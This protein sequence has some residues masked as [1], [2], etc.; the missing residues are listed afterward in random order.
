[1]SSFYCRWVQ[2]LLFWSDPETAH[3]LVLRGLETVSRSQTLC[4]W[5]DHR[6]KTP[7]LPSTRF[8]IRF[9][10]PVGLAAGMDK[11]GVAVP[12][13]EALGF[14]FCEI[15]GVTPRPQSGNPK[16]RIFRAPE[17][18]ALIN[19]LGFNNRGADE[20]AARLGRS[21]RRFPLGINL[22]KSRH[23]PLEEAS[24]DY[25]YSFR[26]LRSLADFVV[27]NVSSP[28]TPGLRNLQEKTALKTLLE[29]LTLA[30]SEVPAERKPLLL[31][32]SPDLS[33][34]EID[35]AIELALSFEL[36]GVV[37]TNTT[38]ARPDTEGHSLPPAYRET[39][40][41]SGQPL[42]RRSTELVRHIAGRAGRSLTV[43]GVGGIHDAESCWE[44]IAAGAHLC[45][46]YTGLVFRGPQLVSSILNGLVAQLR[47][48]GLDNWEAAIGS[49]LPYI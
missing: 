26:R 16:P 2:P 28:N 32:L 49:E 34:S 6:L 18:E 19:R 21:R 22:G 33:L 44:K 11:N 36:A 8:G 12:A 30:D 17:T 41:L 29:T 15:G 10:N 45:Q 35:D 27:L 14:G 48:H 1:M 42:R 5:I 39:G 40:G 3:G 7:L 47:R 46:L 25:L 43:V 20:I 23:T 9:P 4:D 38:T 24:A 31:K 37:A 13:W